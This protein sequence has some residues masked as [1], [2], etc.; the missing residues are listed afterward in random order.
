LL[1]S[2]GPALTSLDFYS[3][4]SDDIEKQPTQDTI[5]IKFKLGQ[6]SLQEIQAM[7]IHEVPRLTKQD[8]EQAAHFLHVSNQVIEEQA[9][10]I[11]R[12]S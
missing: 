1:C 6:R 9:P 11:A 12:L 10:I 3:P 8:K 2:Q 7:V 4:S 5:S